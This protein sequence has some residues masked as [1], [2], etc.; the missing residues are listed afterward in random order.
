MRPRRELEDE[1]SLFRGDGDFL[2]W[3]CDLA[4]VRP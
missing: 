1:I 4:S 2:I 3:E